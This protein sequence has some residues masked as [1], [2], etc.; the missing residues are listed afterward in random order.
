L[1]IYGLKNRAVVL[2]WLSH[3]DRDGH[4][5]LIK[6]LEPW[7][8]E[9]ARALRLQ[10]FERGLIA[11]G[12]TSKARQI[13]PK[14]LENGDVGDPWM[15]LNT[16]DKKKGISALTLSK[17]GW[18]PQLLT[19]LLFKKG[20]RLTPLQEPRPGEGVAWFVASCLARSQGKTEGFHRVEIPVPPKVQMTL[21]HK[22]KRD[23]LGHL[24]E[25]LLTDAGNVKSAFTAALTMLTEGGPEKPD[26]E[27]IDKWLKQA[28]NDFARRWEALFFPTLWRG[29]E[30]AHE[31]V[32][33]DWQQ[34]LVDA[35]QALLNEAHERMPL[36]TNRTWRAITQGQKTFREQLYK[37]HLPMPR[38]TRN[39][40]QPDEEIA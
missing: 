28:G 23:T 24:A 20:Y 31:T 13:G 26:F 14:S 16:Q 33:S 4:Q 17:E 6:D 7:F 30:E 34:A 38:I 15:P 8:I 10:P 32:R 11:L 3:W 35:A 40:T 39:S 9:T 21:S 25:A 1:E 22:P 37:H 5:Y 12:A 19:N 18:T 27:R 2:T 36:P 29:A